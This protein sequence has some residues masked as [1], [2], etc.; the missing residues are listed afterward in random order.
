M[1]TVVSIETRLWD[2]RPRFDSLQGF[3]I[4]SRHRVQT[5][6]GAHQHY[7]MDSGDSFPRSKAVG[8]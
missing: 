1:N 4:F 7:L 8:S 5:G 6:S 2:G 3:V